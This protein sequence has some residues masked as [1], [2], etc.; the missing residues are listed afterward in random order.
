MEVEDYVFGKRK[1]GKPLDPELYF[2]LKNG[3]KIVEVI[4]GYMHDPESLDYGVLIRW[5]NPIYI[6]TR[7]FPLKWMIRFISSFLILRTPEK[8]Q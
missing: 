5:D 8:I 7:M 1:S 6:I 3:F 2:Y 4:P